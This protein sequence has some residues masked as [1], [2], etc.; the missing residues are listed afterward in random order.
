MSNFSF[1]VI[2]NKTGEEADTYKIALKEDWAK[3]LMYCD[4]EG[5]AISEDGHLLLLDECGN[6]AYCPNDRFIIIPEGSVVLSKEEHK[7]LYNEE[8]ASY[9]RAENL[10]IEND[11]LNRKLI[12]ARKETAREFANLPDSDILVVDTQEYGEI[13]VVSV[14]RLQELA[15]EFGVEVEE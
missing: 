10:A 7:Q 9:Y 6:V 12:D 1:R 13:E 15:N 3:G 8:R 2:D 5:F 4:M 11:L 14:E